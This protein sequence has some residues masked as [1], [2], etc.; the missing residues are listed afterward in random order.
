MEEKGGN[1]T[2]F[3]RWIPSETYFIKDIA[4]S[5]SLHGYLWVSQN[6]TALIKG[7]SETNP[8]NF[9]NKFH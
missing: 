2:K 9:P 8:S 6:E 3:M 1:C 7:G 4:L 5:L